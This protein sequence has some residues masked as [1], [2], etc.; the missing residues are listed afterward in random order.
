[1]TA[2]D[3]LVFR[4]AVRIFMIVWI[5]EVIRN[6]VFTVGLERTVFAHWFCATLKH[7]L[8][9]FFMGVSW[10]VCSLDLRW[11]LLRRLTAFGDISQYLIWIILI[12]GIILYL[13]SSIGHGSVF[14][15]PGWICR[16]SIFTRTVSEHLV[17]VLIKSLL[18][19]SIWSV[20]AFELS[21]SLIFRVNLFIGCCLFWWRT[22]RIFVSLPDFSPWFLKVWF[23]FFLIG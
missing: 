11:D 18:V 20:Q 9:R 13:N 1:M 10:L 22:S 5:S 6:R 19:W 16:S 15:I 14:I 12:Y 21:L 3:S 2:F 8:G 23:R 4:T 7:R 17:R